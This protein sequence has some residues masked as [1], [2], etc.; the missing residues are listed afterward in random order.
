MLMLLTAAQAAASGAPPRPEEIAALVR[1]AGGA[2]A[3]A[4]LEADERLW[5]GVLDG[6]ASGRKP[7]LEVGR[8][9]R[10]HSD[11]EGSEMLDLALAEALRPAAEAVLEI[12][13]GTVWQVTDA[14]GSIGFAERGASDGEYIERFLDERRRAVRAVQREDLAE[15]RDQCLD[16]LERA[17]FDLLGPTQ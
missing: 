17:E 1:D 4:A 13:D 3:T 15:R 2:T 14:C 11:E 10:R 7:W 16:A 12:A 5:R 9:L 8:D 6:V